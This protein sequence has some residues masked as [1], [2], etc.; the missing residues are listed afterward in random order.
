MGDPNRLEDYIP[1]YLEY[2][3]FIRGCKRL[4]L[5]SYR[6]AFTVWPRLGYGLN[7]ENATS[8]S[9]EARKRGLAPATVN[10]YLRS[11][12]SFWRWLHK[13]GDLPALPDVPLLPEPRKVKAIFDG[14]QAQ[15]VLRV[16]VTARGLKRIQTFFAVALDTGLRY[17]E[18]ASLRRGDIDA[19]S[20]L[21]TVDGKT[22]QRRV[23][24]SDHGLAW[25]T[26]HLQTHS[27]DL[28][29]CSNLGVEVHYANA[30]RDLRKLFKKAGVAA[31]LAQFHHVRRYALRHYVTKAGLRGAQLLAGHSKPET[32]LRYLDADAELR[33]LPHQS[34]SPLAWLSGR[35][36]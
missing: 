25:L 4:T 23:P 12:K 35:R 19:R 20:T 11:L 30:L 17:G 36:R 34:I 28:V 15:A 31:E 7:P 3:E 22:G 13:R 16:K 14:D 33:A 2:C 32:T 21:L 24:I 9:V 10:N 18:L 8:A 27:F 5:V 1:E 6:Q 26:R 29:F